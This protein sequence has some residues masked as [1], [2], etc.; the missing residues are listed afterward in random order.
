M[1]NN[2][3]KKLNELIATV[4]FTGYSPFMPGTVGTLAGVI[5]YVLFSRFFPIYNIALIL[6]III[7]VRV[8]DY[9]EKN[10][11]KSKDSSH[12]VI[13]EV[14]G[15]LISMISFEFSGSVESIKF[16]VVGFILF[17]IFDIWKPYPIKQSQKLEGGLG[18]VI[19]DLMA[20]IYTN[21][22]LQFLRFKFPFFN[23]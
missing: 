15:Y 8:S 14:I 17:R 16:M 3:N 1:I 19:D 11:F 6:L 18:V 20:G 7:S 13:D 9:A 23:L 10:I 5:I 22:L 12:I 21:L 4:F 2:F